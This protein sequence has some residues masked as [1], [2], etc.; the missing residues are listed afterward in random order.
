MSNVPVIGWTG[1]HSTIKYLDILLPVIRRLE[2][3]F[4]FRFMVIADK[5]PRLSL[6]SYEFR[7]WNKDREI[8]DLLEFNIGVMPLS[9]DPWAKGKCG[10]K[11]LQYMALGIPAVVSPVG[12]NALIVEGGVGGYICNSEESWYGSLKKLLTQEDLRNEMGLKARKK[13]ESF[14]SVESNKKNFLSLF[15]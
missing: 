6:K 4:T 11:A 3:E 13:V 7:Q 1:T 10:F 14:Y 12:V 5:D 15:E 2:R 9:D 8:E